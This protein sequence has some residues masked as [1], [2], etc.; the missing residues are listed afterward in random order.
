[1][2]E[3]TYVLVFSSL[4]R[5]VFEQQQRMLKMRVREYKSVVVVGAGTLRKDVQGKDLM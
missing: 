4:E 5:I 1:M 3:G 2:L